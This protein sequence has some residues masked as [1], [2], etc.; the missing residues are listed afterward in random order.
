MLKISIKACLLKSYVLLK[1]KLKKVKNCSIS[2]NPRLGFG[3]VLKAKTSTCL[4][5]K[6]FARLAKKVSSDLSL[7]N[8]L[9]RGPLKQLLDLVK[10]WLL[11]TLALQIHNALNTICLAPQ[12]KKFQDS[13]NL[14]PVVFVLM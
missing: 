6:S 8:I 11:I 13:K 14:I 10:F 9:P 3:S 4:W 12:R 2:K 5:K 7:E 1:S